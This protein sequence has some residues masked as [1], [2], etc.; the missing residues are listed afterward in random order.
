M[1]TVFLTIISVAILGSGAAYYAYSRPTKSTTILGT[2]AVQRGDLVSTISATGTIEAEEVVNIGAQ[3][4]GL[5]VEFGPDRK[6]PSKPVDFCS[7]VEKGDL[8]AKI[9][10]T[11]YKA[12]LEQAEATLQKSEADL[13]QLRAKLRQTQREWKRAQ[14]LHPKNAIADTD[15][16]TALSNYES[17]EAAVAAGVATIRQ[18]KASVETARINLGY[19]TINSPV[20]GT[21]VERRVNI[22][23]TVVASL[24]APSLF[25]IAKDLTKMQVWASVNEADIGRIR[26][27]MPVRFTVDAHPDETFIGAVTQIRMNA[28]MT[29]NVVT[30]TVIVTTDNTKGKLLPYLTANVQFEVEKRTNVL[31]AP[32]AAL[33]WTPE[34]NQLDP[35]VD[36]KTLAA[37]ATEVAGRGR[38][39]LVGDRNLV[40]P[41]D[42]AVG[43]TDGTMTE[44]S[45]ND[46]RAGMQIVTG[47]QEAEEI[48]AQSTQTTSANEDKTSNPFLP[49]MPK[50]S[51]PPPGPM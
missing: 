1:R 21:V 35:S 15:Y 23:Q 36:Q 18:N 14:S 2:V 9:D 32:N 37:D 33:R 16:D 5:I 11:C 8:L 24:N 10:P 12:A 25:L 28:Q 19:C 20:H 42:V 4:A 30:Y 39:W 44:V 31:L 51:K 41:I 13:M 48:E 38:L 34:S 46:L 7:V 3:V 27:N 29:S 40:R 50:G 6:A 47:D 45:G 26:L 17:A 22:G 43:A 49:K